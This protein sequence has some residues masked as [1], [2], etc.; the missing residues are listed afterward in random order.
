M[1]DCISLGPKITVDG[2]CSHE[3]KR[4]LLLERKAMTNPHIVF[5]SRDITLLTKVCIVKATVFPVVINECEHWTKKKALS[6][7]IDAFKLWCWRRLSRVP[8]TAKKS[9]QSILKES[10][11]DYSLEELRLK[12]K[13]QYFGQLMGRADSLEETLTLGKIEGRRRRKR[14]RMRVG[15]HH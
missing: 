14:Q 1:T 12:L 11:P 7:R 4:H 3:T 5:K 6:Q 9:N 13:L 8:W 10:N 15:W 2:D